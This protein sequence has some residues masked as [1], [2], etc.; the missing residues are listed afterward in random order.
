MSKS[1]PSTFRSTTKTVRVACIHMN[2]VTRAGIVH[3]S[4]TK[5]IGPITLIFSEQTEVPVPVPARQISWIRT[6]KKKNEI[7][8]EI[9]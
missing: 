6:I 2:I 9:T 1:V 4:V 7:Y 5:I 8:G 3:S